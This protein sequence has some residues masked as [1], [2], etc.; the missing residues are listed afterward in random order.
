MADSKEVS[1]RATRI[2]LWVFSTLLVI[3]AGSA[4]L[5]KLID[6]YI[7]ATREGTAALGSFLVPVMNYLFVAAG[8]GALFVW[9]YL[10]G[11]F[12]DVE[13]P[14]YKMLEQNLRWEREEREQAR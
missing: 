6:F 1:P 2:F 3:T 4:F 13:G 11:E 7:T 10:R 9:A 14:K 5:M 12:R 8:F